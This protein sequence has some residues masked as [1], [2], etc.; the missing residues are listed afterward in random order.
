MQSKGII[1]GHYATLLAIDCAAATK[2][3]STSAGLPRTSRHGWIHQGA[4]RDTVISSKARS[5]GRPTQQELTLACL[6]FVVMCGVAAVVIEYSSFE[7]DTA[8][9]CRKFLNQYLPGFL[10][11]RISQLSESEY[12]SFERAMLPS[13]PTSSKAMQSPPS[14]AST[15]HIKKA[16]TDCTGVCDQLAGN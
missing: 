4:W 5:K 1:V 9:S 3:T 13:D 6:A 12:S 15:K 14:N 10:K 2:R 7:S 8:D 16:D 11:L